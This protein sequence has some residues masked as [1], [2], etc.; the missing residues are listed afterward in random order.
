MNIIY[1]TKIGFIGLGKLGMPCAEAIA[2]KGFDVAGYDIVS[3]SSSFIEMREDI[4]DVCRDRDIIFVATP[5]PHEDGYD[6]SSPTSHMPVKDFNYDAVKKVL[7]KCNKHMGKAQTL[8]LISTVLPGTCRRE[9]QPLVTNTKLMYNP[10][11]IAMGTVA[12]DMINPEMIMIGSKNGL[13]GTNCK[14]RSELLESFYNQVCD[15]MPRV[16]FGTFEEVESMKI[17]YNTFISNKVALVNMI[18]DVAHK[19]GNMNVDIVTTALAKSTQRIVSPAY[20]KAG[21][22]DGGACHPRDN[23][24]LRWLAKELD[25]GYDM[26]ETIM[27]AREKQAENMALAILEHG[28]NIWFSSDSYKAGTELVD[29][30]SSLLVQYYVKK[31]GGTLANGIDTPVEVIVRV[32]DSDEFTADDKTIIFDPWR[33]Y[34]PADNVFYYGQSI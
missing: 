13:K 3:K 18:Q 21:M 10:Y 6:G 28:T 2:Q 25:L 17:F 4:E 1:E 8:V 11:L 31:H 23:I 7:T 26:F 34:P 15:N 24:A 20:M 33:S 5:T 27:T 14:V 22:G 29:G 9:L 30:S 12:W 16:E 19:L 32:H